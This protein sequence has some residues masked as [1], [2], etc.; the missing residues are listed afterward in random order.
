MPNLNNEK[1]SDQKIEDKDVINIL[2]LRGTMA[3][4]PELFKDLRETLQQDLQAGRLS[5]EDLDAIAE[6]V[7]RLP[8]IEFD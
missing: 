4:S 3:I 7:Q 8:K 2:T 6:R 1:P 5:R